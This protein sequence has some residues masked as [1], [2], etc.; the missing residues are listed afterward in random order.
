MKSRGYKFGAKIRLVRERRGLTLKDVAARAQVS[1]SLISQ[2]ERDKVS[3]SIDT[4]M[5]VAEVLNLNVEYLFQDFRRK[6]RAV[7]LTPEEQNQL[8][9][10][11]VSYRQ[12]A[13]HPE[14][15]ESPSLEVLKVEIPPGCSKGDE[16]FGHI[17]REVG[18]ILEGTGELTYGEEVLPLGRG[19]TVA[20][21]SDMPHIIRNTGKEPLITLWVI[22][23][24][25]IFR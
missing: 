10:G 3:P 17:G 2:I 4:L 11:G 5:A 25:R 9:L 14:A 21:T 6:K 7:V 19:D 24:G 12:M 1:E 15:P 8:I 20:F 23:P 22:T 16:E 18:I 13:F